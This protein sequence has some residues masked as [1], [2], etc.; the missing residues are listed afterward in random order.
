MENQ[1]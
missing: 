1:K